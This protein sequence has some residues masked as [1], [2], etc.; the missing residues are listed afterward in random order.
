MTGVKSP[1]T[2]AWGGRTYSVSVLTGQATPPYPGLVVAAAG[3]D[4][5]VTLP[6]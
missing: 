5:S 1:F 6:A 2:L 3:K 4:V